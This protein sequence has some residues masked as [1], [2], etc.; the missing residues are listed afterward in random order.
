MKTTL[1]GT[2]YEDKTRICCWGEE[3]YFSVHAFFTV[4]IF[5]P[6]HVQLFMKLAKITI[7]YKHMILFLILIQFNILPI[8]G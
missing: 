3:T 2:S 5:S 7:E 8:K 1:K 6:A 4:L